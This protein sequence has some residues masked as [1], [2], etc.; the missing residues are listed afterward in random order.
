LNAQSLFSAQRVTNETYRY[1]TSARFHPSGSK[2]I[3]SKWYTGRITIAAS[4]GWLYDLP[5]LS[6]EQAPG[7]IQTGSGEC[8]LGRTLPPGKTVD[9]YADQQIGPEQFIWYTED[10]IIFAK[11]AV[12]EYITSEKGVVYEPV[13]NSY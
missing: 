2:I 13:S 8:V 7:S 1:V 4:E 9:D 3:A 10:T 6:T 5:D 11:N 12:D